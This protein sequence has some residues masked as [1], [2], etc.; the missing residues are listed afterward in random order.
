MDLHSLAVV[1]CKLSSE[2]KLDAVDII[3]LD[4]ILTQIDRHPEVS[5]TSVT[6]N[7]RL[8][9]KSNAHARYKKLVELEYLD[10]E[11]SKRHTSVRR[12]KRGRKLPV[13]VSY[14]K[15]TE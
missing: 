13:L 10:W 9:G 5:V 2:C 6:E 3:L 12:L 15:G 7:F 8:I 11:I 1:L 4:Y 14:L